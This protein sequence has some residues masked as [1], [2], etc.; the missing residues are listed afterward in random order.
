[1]GKNHQ[2][3]VFVLVY[4]KNILLIPQWL[5]VRFLST[6]SG[7]FAGI[8]W[9]VVFAYSELSKL[10]SMLVPNLGWLKHFAMGLGYFGR[11]TQLKCLSILSLLPIFGRLLRFITITI[12][13]VIIRSLSLPPNKNIYSSSKLICRFETFVHLLLS[14]RA[15]GFHRN[16][17]LAPENELLVK[18]D[19]YMLQF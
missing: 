17:Q 6:T 18:G 12:V 5:H 10:K 14:L 15:D 19:V 16:K 2:R 9:M 13:W 11:K 8:S 7:V 4:T 3:C 1:M